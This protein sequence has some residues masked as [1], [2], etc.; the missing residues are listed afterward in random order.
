MMNRK[1][2]AYIRIS[3]ILIAVLFPGFLIN[4]FELD[5]INEITHIKLIESSGFWNLTGSPIFIDDFDPNF[6]WSKTINDNDWCYGSGTWDDPYVIENITIDGNNASNCIEIHNSN[7]FF[8]IK[9]CMLLNSRS[10]HDYAAISLENVNNSRI[11]ENTCSYNNGH[12]IRLING[13]NDTILHNIVH[14]SMWDG[15]FLRYSISNIVSSN[16]VINNHRG[17]R[18]SDCL[19]LNTVD[20]NTVLD[21]F[22]DDVNSAGIGVYS[23]ANV[24]ITNN[25]LKNN[26]KAIYFAQASNVMLRGNNITG[27][28]NGVY[29]EFFNTNIQYIENTLSHCRIG[30]SISSHGNLN[31]SNNIISSCSSGMSFRNTDYAYISGNQIFN[32][33]YAGISLNDNNDSPKLVENQLTDCE[34]SIN[35][36]SDKIHTYNISKSNLVNG[37]PLYFLSSEIDLTSKNFSNP[38][39]II[40]Y[41]CNNSIL[42]D[43]QILGGISLLYCNNITISD[44]NIKSQYIGLDLEYCNNCT[45][46]DNRISAAAYCAINFH[47]IKLCTITDNE[48]QGYLYGIFLG[49]SSENIIFG[50]NCTECIIGIELFISVENNVTRN[51]F[52]KNMVGIYISSSATNSIKNNVAVNNG[53]HGISLYGS[54]DNDLINN[55]IYKNNITG[56]AVSVNSN[57]NL[58]YNNNF[59]ENY[60]N[61]Q[62][63]GTTNLWDNGII[64]NYWDDYMGID[65]DNNNIGDM[66]YNIS[67]LARSQDN[68]P[69]FTVSIPPPM[70]T[71]QSPVENSLFGTTAPTIY[72]HTESMFTDTI[73]Y[74]MDDGTITTNNFTFTGAIDH[75]DLIANGTVR[76]RIYINDT[77]GKVTFT[78]IL[79]RKDIIAPQITI[80]SPTSQ[81]IYEKTPPTFDLSIIEGNLDSIWYSF[82]GGITNYQC[83]TTGQINQAVWDSLAEGTITIRFYANDT[84]G[85]VDFVE[86]NVNKELLQPPS[87]PSIIPGYNIAFLLGVILVMMIFSITIKKLSKKRLNN[88]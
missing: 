78:E 81:N 87:T 57:N 59:I 67:G 22:E 85:N 35:S 51:I 27:S 84:L 8:I 42:S 36:Y 32:C 74:F 26:I 44:T 23:S 48:L 13:I 61:A 43:L 33:S 39:Q 2:K 29:M 17:I 64:G 24:V 14:N 73:W 11:L 82:D 3:V 12:G 66:P 55:S 88:L 38:G 37:K 65:G 1:F 72:I 25:I 80:N 16:I 46:L 70:I 15:I 77:F 41:N 86:I 68:F 75:W 28:D 53:W 49:D 45:I 50:N 5:K 7:K 54:S 52:S 62:D 19:G 83:S 31:V 34:V 60:L 9:N 30:F 76:I 71:I 63:N 40:L 79:L 18:I 69:I 56:I 58:I 47:T 10:G 4:N 20:N 21:H 6:N